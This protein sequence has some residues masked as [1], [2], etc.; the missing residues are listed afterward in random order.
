MDTDSSLGSQR[1]QG[2]TER[3]MGGEIISCLRLLVIIGARFPIWRDM[4]TVKEK[5]IPRK[6]PLMFC[7][8]P[9]VACRML[10]DQA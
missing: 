7:P 5:Q 4:Y 8:L 9:F 6:E 10:F 1:R 3:E 2:E